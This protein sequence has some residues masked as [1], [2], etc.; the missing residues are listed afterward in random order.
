M[1][2][3]E[4]LVTMTLTNSGLKDFMQN[5]NRSIESLLILMLLTNVEQNQKPI[6]N[7]LIL[8]YYILP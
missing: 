7:Q 4:Q 1:K 8:I 6:I 2:K 3:S 5:D